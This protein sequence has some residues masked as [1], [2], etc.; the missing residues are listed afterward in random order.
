[1]IWRKKRNNT[2][3]VFFTGRFPD[4]HNGEEW[5]RYTK[6]FRWAHTLCAGMEE[7]FVCELFSG[8]NTVLFLVCALYVCNF[9]N[10]VT[11]LCAFY[12]NYSP[13]QMRNT[14]PPNYGIR[15]FKKT[16]FTH[17]FLFLIYDVY[18]TTVSSLIK[19]SFACVLKSDTTFSEV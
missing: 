18:V 12:V 16:N 2:L 11:I 5:I 13:P 17:A 6:Y 19:W 15:S 9:F 10:S 8:I 1:M 14:C 3:N 7:Q 4:D